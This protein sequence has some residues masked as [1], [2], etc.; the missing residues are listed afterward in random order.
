MLA[1]SC[2]VSGKLSL[3]SMILHHTAFPKLLLSSFWV[4]LLP[5]VN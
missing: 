1:K 4:S 5:W 2:L 3:G